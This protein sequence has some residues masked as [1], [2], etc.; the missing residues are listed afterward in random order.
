MVQI[1]QGDLEGALAS[2]EKI[3]ACKGG[4]A[5]VELDAEHGNLL[6]RMGRYEE[7]IPKFQELYA[8]GVKIARYGKIW[9]YLQA[10]LVLYHNLG[11]VPLF[12]LPFTCQLLTEQV[13][14]SEAPQLHGDIM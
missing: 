12:R 5:A 6:I 3:R 10:N 1:R 7:A 14:T 4:H 11:C 13:R 2:L 8:N 9:A